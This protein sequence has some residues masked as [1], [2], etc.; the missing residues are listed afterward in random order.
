MSWWARTLVCFLPIWFISRI[1]TAGEKTGKNTSADLA[2]LWQRSGTLLLLKPEIILLRF[3][4]A[5]KA[6]FLHR[7][8]IFFHTSVAILLFRRRRS[9]LKSWHNNNN[10]N[11]YY[12]RQPTLKNGEPPQ[13]FVARLYLLTLE[14]L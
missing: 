2:Y 14:P 1:N 7:V 11:S 9:P 5:P 6:V 4:F 3:L 12:N 8:W 13:K 10:P